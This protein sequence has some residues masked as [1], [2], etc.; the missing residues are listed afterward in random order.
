[1]PTT[2]L[3]AARQQLTVRSRRE[4]GLKAVMMHATAQ[5]TTIRR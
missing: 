2:R 5:A 4:A 1:V 3:Q